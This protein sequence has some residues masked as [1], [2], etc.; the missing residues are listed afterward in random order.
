VSKRHG[1][2]RPSERTAHI[3][4]Q[5]FGPVAVVHSSGVLAK[6]ARHRT[7]A[8]FSAAQKCPLLTLLIDVNTTTKRVGRLAVSIQ[9]S[10]GNHCLE[11]RAGLVGEFLEDASAV[12]WIESP[13]AM[14]N[15]HSRW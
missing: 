12:R 8:R 15:V 10:H 7:R 13:E 5:R 4:I 1:G 2:R 9:F 6:P 11:Y 14:F 3:D